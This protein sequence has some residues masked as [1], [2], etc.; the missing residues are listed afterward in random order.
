MFSI[1]LLALTVS[2][3]ASAQQEVITTVYRADSRAPEEVFRNGFSGSGTVISVLEHAAAGRCDISSGGPRSRWVSMSADHGYATRFAENRL[4]YTG[5]LAT[6][7]R[8]WIYEIR[9]DSTYLSVVGI[10]RQALAAAEAESDGYTFAHALGIR[11]ATFQTSVFME[12]EVLTE[13]VLPIN[14]RNATPV[15][16]DPE[17]DLVSGGSSFNSLYVVANT[18]ATH[19]VPDLQSVIPAASIRTDYGNAAA[20]CSMTCDR[21]ASSS[22]RSIVPEP[23]ADGFC[24]AYGKSG[25]TPEKLMIILD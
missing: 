25:L 8:M 9:P 10:L 16:L 7:A 23:Y 12:R 2:F 3:K 15:W 13:R 24:A 14:I 6:G 18:Q 5:G 21:A 19:T 11:R 4:R 22:S 17:G 1:V 20:S